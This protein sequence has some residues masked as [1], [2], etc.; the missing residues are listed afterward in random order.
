MPS[1]WLILLRLLTGMAIASASMDNDCHHVARARFRRFVGFS[2][3][4]DRGILGGFLA[5]A[6]PLVAA[7]P[8]LEMRDKL[9]TAARRGARLA[10]GAASPGS[11]ISRPNKADTSSSMSR[12][13]A[14]GAV[15]G[16]E[17][18]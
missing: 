3:A 17:A 13:A 10:G 7:T 14:V 1:L 5:L 11:A 12:L 4:V 2:E 18:P 15:R 6:D 8:P 9:S 16:P